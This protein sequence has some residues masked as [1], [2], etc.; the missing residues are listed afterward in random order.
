[1]RGLKAWRYSFPLKLSGILWERRVGGD[2]LVLNTVFLFFVFAF[3]PGMNSS[4]IFSASSQ[5]KDCSV[6]A[7]WFVS[8]TT[9]APFGQWKFTYLLLGLLDALTQNFPV[10]NTRT[11]RTDG[12][13]KHWFRKGSRLHWP[14][15]IRWHGSA[16]SF[17]RSVDERALPIWEG[18]RLKAHFEEMCLS[19]FPAVHPTERNQCPWGC[20]GWGFM[21]TP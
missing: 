1:M 7:H 2:E 16:Q 17:G 3:L 10:S 14:W 5:A 8:L 20:W 21:S 11:A 6:S 18:L 9:L 19:I 15:N 4:S 13:T 12:R